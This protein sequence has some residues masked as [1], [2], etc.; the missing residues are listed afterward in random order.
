[1]TTSNAREL[2]D[3]ATAYSAGALSGRNNTSIKLERTGR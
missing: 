2:A 3:F 1:M